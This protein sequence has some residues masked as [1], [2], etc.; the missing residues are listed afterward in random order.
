LADCGIE[1]PEYLEGSAPG[2]LDKGSLG[3]PLPSKHLL[4]WFPCPKLLLCA[5]DVVLPHLNSLILIFKP[6]HLRNPNLFYKLY[7]SISF[8]L[9]RFIVRSF[10]AKISDFI[11]SR[12][13]Q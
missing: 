8:R 4:R 1:V 12:K 6:G 10:S 7:H 2:N 13:N 3:F 9:E 5:S 11:F